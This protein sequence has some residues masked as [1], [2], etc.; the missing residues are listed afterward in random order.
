[1]NVIERIEQGKRIL[2]V[3]HPGCGCFDED[4]TNEIMH[5]AKIGQSVVCLKNF[6]T[7]KD[8]F[9]ELSQI[10]DIFINYESPEDDE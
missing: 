9:K 7:E 8:E 10:C 4:S 2:T 5:L 6:C 1:M 3:N